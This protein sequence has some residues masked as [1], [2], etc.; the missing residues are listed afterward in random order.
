MKIALTF[1]DGPDPRWTPA[2]LDILRAGNV[3]ATFYMVGAAVAAWPDLASRVLDEGHSIGTHSMT[4]PP[5]HVSPEN[6]GLEYFMSSFILGRAV[7]GLAG[8]PAARHRLP[9]GYN[10]ERDRRLSSLPG[11]HSDGW[12]VDSHDWQE[13]GNTALDL[14][15]YITQSI[16]NTPKP[17]HV[18]L[19]HD[20]AWQNGQRWPGRDRQR[21][22][23]LLAGILA[24]YGCDYLTLGQ[25]E[26]DTNRKAHSLL[27]GV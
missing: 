21:T 10:G 17:D 13:N 7:P 20:G 16:N 14:L 8:K 15:N 5:D 18:I 27:S 4:H 11:V 6:Y 25:W 19:L 22:I 9:H 24:T 2:V 12:T 26:R 23:D 3:K 1:D